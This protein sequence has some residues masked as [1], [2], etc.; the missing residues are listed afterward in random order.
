MHPTRALPIAIAA[1]SLMTSAAGAAGRTP[2]SS[3]PVAAHTGTKGLTAN[4]K[5]LDT[6]S[7]DPFITDAATDGFAWN[8]ETGGGSGYNVGGYSIAYFESSN[9]VRHPNGSFTV[10]ETPGTLQPGYKWTSGVLS[11]YGAFSVTGGYIS[12]EAQM[13]SLNDGAWPGLFLL[14]GPGNTKNDEIDIFEGGMTLGTDDPNY[15][16]SGFVHVNAKASG[17]TLKVRSSLSGVYHDYGIKW[18]PGKSITW[19]LDGRQ[20][21]QVTSKNFT[22]PT[23]TMELVAELEMVSPQAKTWHS[24]PTILQNYR[25]NVKSIVVT[26]ASGPAPWTTP[27][28]TASP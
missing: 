26:P 25:M 13:P 8:P 24:L 19:Y 5:P 16:F 21:F 6:S 1:V 2:S 28:S 17:D 10:T 14:P 7:W 20:L 15:N 18:L 22:I 3:V 23:G 27:T 12:I 4:A 11:S 9:V